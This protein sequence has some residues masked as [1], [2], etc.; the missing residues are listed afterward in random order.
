[1]I[2][3]MEIRRKVLEA[4]LTYKAIAKRMGISAEYLSRSLRH[5]TIK[6]ELYLRIIKAIYSLQDKRDDAV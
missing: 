4:R 2:E 3:S 6:P 5:E 1:M